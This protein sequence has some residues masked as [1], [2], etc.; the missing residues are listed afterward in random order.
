MPGQYVDTLPASAPMPTLTIHD[1]PDWLHAR[2]AA[3]NR[4]TVD[5]E[6][7][8]VLGVPLVTSDKQVLRGVSRAV[9]PA[10]FV[11]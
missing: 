3:A 4:R 2:L 1:L 9:T 5:A 7:R 11:A 8:A 6:A 10:A